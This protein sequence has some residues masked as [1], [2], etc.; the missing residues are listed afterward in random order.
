MAIMALSISEE[1]EKKLRDLN[2]HKGDMSKIINE[3]LEQW[4]ERNA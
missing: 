1:N 4:F 2:R 3:A